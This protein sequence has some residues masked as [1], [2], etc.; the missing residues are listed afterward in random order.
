MLLGNPREVRIRTTL[1]WGCGKVRSWPGSW[2][3]APRLRW[4]RPR[5]RGRPRH[6]SSRSSGAATARRSREWTRRRFVHSTARASRSERAIG[7]GRTRRTGRRSPSA[8]RAFV[9]GGG[10]PLAE[11]R[12][13]NLAVRYHTLGRPLDKAELTGPTRYACWVGNGLLAVAGDDAK[14]QMVDG[15]FLSETKPSGLQLVDTRT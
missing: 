4:V 2:R 7:P 13:S 10:A 12:L 11:I 6:R 3:W 14:G 5:R 1:Q 8:S 15:Q 9:V